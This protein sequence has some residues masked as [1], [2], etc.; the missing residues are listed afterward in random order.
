MGIF[1]GGDE[2]NQRW[3]SSS[4]KTTKQKR[5]KIRY[6]FSKKRD[7][8]S[9]ITTATLKGVLNAISK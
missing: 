3:D 6:R 8:I 5:L 4:I 1:F 9:N 7:A 2:E